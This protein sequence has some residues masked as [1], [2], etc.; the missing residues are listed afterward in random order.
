MTKKQL[1][2]LQRIIDREASRIAWGKE[3]LKETD[4]DSMREAGLHPSRDRYVVTDGNV[5]IIFRDKPEGVHEVERMDGLYDIMRTEIEFNDQFYDH[6][7]ALTVTASRINE[8]K[9]MSFAWK[10]G[11]TSKTGAIPVKLTAQRE[12]GGTL[13]GFY[14]PRYVLDAAEAI[15]PG[16]MLYIGRYSKNSPFCSLLVFPRDWME[17]KDHVTGYVLPLRMM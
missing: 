8:W 4:Q 3:R 2:A 1:A 17:N 15:G 9:H 14:D 5:A 12:D 10:A 7:L 6:L 13:E 11:K 16:A